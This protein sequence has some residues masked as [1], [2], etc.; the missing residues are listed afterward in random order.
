M[1]EEELARAHAATR[2][3][4]D[5]TVVQAFDTVA[6]SIIDKIRNS[7]P[8]QKDERELAYHLYYATLEAKKQLRKWAN[9]LKVHEAANK[10][11]D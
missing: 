3:L 1:T 10:A 4:G 6:E 7:A 11:A 2:L 9:D 8:V 5:E